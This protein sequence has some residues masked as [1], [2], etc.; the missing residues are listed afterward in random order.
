MRMLIADADETYLEILQSY[1]WDRGCEVEIAADGLECMAIL[2]EFVPEVLVVERDLLWGGCEGVLALMQATAKLT[3]I[4][5]VLVTNGDHDIP[6]QTNRL[7]A[8]RLAKPFRLHDLL[9][10][11]THVTGAAR[12]AE[13]TQREKA[14]TKVTD[15]H[16]QAYLQSQNDWG[17]SREYFP[18]GVAMKGI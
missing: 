6:P 1:F 5:V 2:R 17:P 7:I 3:D 10:R 15:S 16:L 14:I 8:T 18:L 4:P 13:S 11:I 9:K 12:F